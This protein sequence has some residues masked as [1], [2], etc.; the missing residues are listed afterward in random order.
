[1]ETI[2]IT[3]LIVGLMVGGV[4]GVSMAWITV[5]KWKPDVSEQEH[6][7]LSYQTLLQTTG[8]FLADNKSTIHR[9]R[10][11]MDELHQKIQQQEEIFIQLKSG[12][13]GTERSTFFGQH[14]SE[15]LKTNVTNPTQAGMVKDQQPQDFSTMRS[16]LWKTENESSDSRPPA[17]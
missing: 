8:Q 16:G 15:F 13:D 14:A 12:I 3:S 9:L 7:A 17:Q 11:D 10:H 4:L 1:M 2:D 5:K 6:Q